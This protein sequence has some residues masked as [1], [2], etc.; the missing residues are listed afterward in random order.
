MVVLKPAFSLGF[1]LFSVTQ[2]FISTV[3]STRKSLYTLASVH[4]KHVMCSNANV[5]GKRDLKQNSKHK[6]KEE[7]AG[8]YMKY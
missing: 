7:L 8:R 4:G 1:S 3:F 2:S 6:E 5:I